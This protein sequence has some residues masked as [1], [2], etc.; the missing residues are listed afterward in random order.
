MTILRSSPIPLYHQ[1]ETL[2]REKLGAGHYRSGELLPTDDDLCRQYGVSKITVRKAMQKLGADGLVVRA[3]GRGTSVTERAVPSADL[4]MTCF[5][6]DL[7]ALG[8]PAEV[9][10][11]KSGPL[12]VRGAVAKALDVPAGTEVFSFQKLLAVSGRPFAL[13]T[14]FVLRH[15]GAR[16]TP[17]DLRAG[18][19]LRKLEERCGVRLRDA[20]QIIESSMANP[21]VAAHLGTSVGAPILVVTRTTRSTADRPVEHGISIYRGDRA[22][23]VV[24]QKRRARARGEWELERRGVR[25]SPGHEAA[26]RAGPRT[27][28]GE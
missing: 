7:I 10:V 27:R 23:F 11:L 9:R 25:R 24:T 19:L 17:R 21:D 13:S 20:E 2:L 14:E 5:L 26:R 28:V 4:K 12:A 18:H 3:R 1:V 6:E 16:L 22:R 8:L 15:L